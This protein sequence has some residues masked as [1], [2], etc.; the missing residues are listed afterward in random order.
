MLDPE[1]IAEADEWF[2]QNEPRHSSMLR[3]S[4]SPTIIDAGYR[5]NVIPS[6]AKGSVDLRAL[7]DENIEDFLDEIRAVIDDESV[8][9]SLGQRNTRPPGEARLDTEAFRVLEAN[10]TK[11][12]DTVT[13]PMM[14]TGAT[15]M[16]YLRNKGVECY[17][18]GPAFDIEDGP[19]GYGA[20]SDQ[21]RILV[22]ELHRFVRFNLDV[23][24]D[25][26]GAATN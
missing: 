2:L 17:G 13:L 23:V 24:I 8:D 25:L 3:S 11:H 20:H 10:I 1:T 22:D 21:E 4:L 9:V 16:A 6:E 19:L 14:Q 26:A 5:I 15:D 7:P 12:Y 18:I